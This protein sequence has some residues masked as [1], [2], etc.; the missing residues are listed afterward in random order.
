MISLIG[1]EDEQRV[2]LIDPVVRQPGEELVEGVIVCFERRDVASLARAKCWST[3]VGVVR[4]RDIG[5]SDGN[6]MLLHRSY[7]G[8]RHSSRH[9]IKAGETD[10]TFGVLNDVAVQIG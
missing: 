1:C 10:V 6:P 3:G 4:I 8:K 5:V 2:A 9:T 7:V